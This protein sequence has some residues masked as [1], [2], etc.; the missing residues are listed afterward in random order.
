MKII[1]IEPTPSPNTMKI[2]LDASLPDGHRYAYLK[3]SSLPV[4]NFI[5]Q[6]LDIPGVDQ[7]FHVA[8]FLAITRHSKAD[9]YPILSKTRELLGDSLTPSALVIESSI[10]ESHYGQ[11]LVKVQVFRS[12]PLHV[13]VILGN[14]EVRLAMPEK[15]TSAALQIGMGSPTFMQER[16]LI[17]LGTRYGD[18][19]EI[20]SEVVAEQAALWD[21]ET[22]NQFV[23]A[24][25]VDD[26]HTINGNLAVSP[27]DI[28]I[29]NTSTH[30]DQTPDHAK[31]TNPN[32]QTRYAALQQVIPSL[33]TLPILLQAQADEHVS[34]RRL[35]TV[36]LADIKLPEIIPYLIRG[37][38]D[39]SPAVRRT[40]GDTLSDIGDSQAIPAMCKALG[41]ENKLVRWRAARFLYDVGDESC[42]AALQSAIFD[43]EY[44][45]R[46][47]VQIAIERIQAGKQAEGTVWQQMTR[48]NETSS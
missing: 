5:Q 14:E 20:A 47:Q 24:L 25:P 37:L 17:E 41:D 18:L 45:V 3:K 32:W 23:H 15:F 11:A 30:R 33:E 36:Y 31:L 13:R 35:A 22:L 21:D 39:R 34:I 2:N 4:P 44:E 29:K 46:M 42:L 6:L 8:N 1:S 19:H 16:K 48:R 43:P 40:A 7:I 26:L 12:I 38:E 9:W 28:E 27:R 10:D